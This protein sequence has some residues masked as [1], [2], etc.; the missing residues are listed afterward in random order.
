MTTN[1]AE[2]LFRRPHC[3]YLWMRYYAY[4][5]VKQRRVK[6]HPQYMRPPGLDAQRP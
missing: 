6:V 1:N 4:D 5:P 2:G 3:R